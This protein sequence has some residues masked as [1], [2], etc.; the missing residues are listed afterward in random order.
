MQATRLMPME[1]S[2]L[3]LSAM[4]HARWIHQN[5][6]PSGQVFLLICPS[7][8]F[9]LIQIASILSWRYIMLSFY[10]NNVMP[11]MRVL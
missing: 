4:Q 9:N 6:S 2:H 5:P 7:I 3:G 11:K 10:N 8:L 1:Q